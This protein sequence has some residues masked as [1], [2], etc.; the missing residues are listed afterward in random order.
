MVLEPLDNLPVIRDLAVDRSSLFSSLKKY[1]LLFSSPEEC[2]RVVQPLEFLQLMRCNECLS[3]LSI[4][5]SFKQEIGYEGAFLGVKL[6]RLR[7]DVREERDRS[8]QLTAFLEKC[9]LCKQCQANCPW[10]IPFTGVAMK[11]KGEALARPSFL[12]RDWVMSRPHMIGYLA[13]LL[14][15]PVNKFG[16]Q[17]MVRRILDRCMEIDERA[18]FPEYNKG[19]LKVR[20]ERPERPKRRVAYFVGCYEKFND[21]D[22]AK[23]SLSLLESTGAEIEVLD[24][25]CCGEPFMG[26]GDLAA[27]RKRAEVISEK[28]R[29]WIQRGFDVVFGCPSCGSMICNDYPSLFQML[30]GRDLQSHLFNMGE[31]LWQMHQSGRLKV[32]FKETRIRIGYQAP[33]HLKAQ[34][35]GVPFVHLLKLIPGLEV[36]A[37]LDKCCGMA[38]TMG[39]KK[40]KFELSQKI[41]KPLFD[42]IQRE[43]LVV[44][45]SDCSACQMKMKKEVGVQS[46]HP[47]VFLKELLQ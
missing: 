2:E 42:E 26:I 1:D 36:Y 45:L 28:L 8:N 12:G 44:V 29:E 6:A 46:Y 18:P 10:D 5:P 39:F 20:K 22:T 37:I 30:T 34:K 17:K 47:V 24:F 3:C 9:I 4:C 38:G 23:A 21:P 19:I 16:K 43:E 7:F 40:E 41:G 25:G 35:I 13:S 33:C 32:K 27:G 14:R 31:Y 11:I 15:L